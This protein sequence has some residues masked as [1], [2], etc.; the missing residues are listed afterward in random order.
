MI[1]CVYISP[2]HNTSHLNALLTYSCYSLILTYCSYYT[3]SFINKCLFDYSYGKKTFI[4]TILWSMRTFYRFLNCKINTA[5]IC[6][7]AE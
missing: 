7:S 6:V 4:I 2:N 3:N 5:Q 1:R